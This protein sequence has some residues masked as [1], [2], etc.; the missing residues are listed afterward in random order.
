MSRTRIWEKINNL[1]TNDPDDVKK[2][3]ENS[4]DAIFL[5]K[6]SGKWIYIYMFYGITGFRLWSF[7]FSKN[8]KFFSMLQQFCEIWQLILARLIREF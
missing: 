7:R 3:F 8:F 1:L 5:E 4:P 6:L 2:T